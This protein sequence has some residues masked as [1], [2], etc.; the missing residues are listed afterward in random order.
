[1]TDTTAAPEA[2][3]AHLGRHRVAN[4]TRWVNAAW[5]LPIG[6]LTSWLGLWALLQDGDDGSAGGGQGLGAALGLGL[7]GLGI[8]LTQAARALRGGGGE[9]FD[10]HEHGLVHGNARGPKGSWRW[11]QVA[12]IT[13]PTRRDSV[14]AFAHRFGNDYRCILT[15]ADGTRVRIDGLA[16]SAPALGNAVID[17]CPDAR[18]LTGEEWTRKAG[19]WL[20]L[21]AA[22]C[23][24]G[25]IAMVDYI[26]G[27][28][29]GEKVTVDAGG[30]TAHE[31]VQGVDDTTIMLLGLG[32]VACGITAV[33]CLSLFVH[34]RTRRAR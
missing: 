26:S 28:P 1:M 11:S 25:I 34:G 22:L 24:G 7:C 23:V 10:V 4:G 17:H 32:M 8:G 6:I 20:L 13:V 15:L 18:L 27:H 3:G 33:A 12:A 2:L 16:T 31:S 5:A 29:D 14:G 9:Y 21:G 19:G 30:H